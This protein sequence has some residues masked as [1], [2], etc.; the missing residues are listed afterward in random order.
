LHDLL[1][2]FQILSLMEHFDLLPFGHE[3]IGSL[4][5]SAKRRLIICTY[6]LSDPLILLFDDPTKDLDALSNYQLIY[7]LNCYMKRCHRIALISLR[8]P[9]SDIYQLMSR[10]TILFY[11][12]VMYSG[13][14]KYMLSYF[15]QIGFPCPSNENPAV[16]YLSL[17]TIDR[18]TSQ[19]Y[20]ESQDQAI[21]LV[22][23]FMVSSERDFRNCP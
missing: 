20:R 16:Y 13:Q 1:I 6:L 10:I 19:R 4:S 8:C 22:N 18:E 17:A 5:E 23:L 11:G 21:K 3:K 14:T 9:R 12:E 15:R 7:S 2:S